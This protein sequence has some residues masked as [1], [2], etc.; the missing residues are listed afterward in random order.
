MTDT[1]TNKNAGRAARRQTPIHAFCGGN[2]GGKSLAM[3][4]D[5]LP[6]LLS[7][8][9]VLSTVELIDARTGQPFENYTRL[10]DWSQ[11]MEARNCDILFDEVVGIAG[12]REHAGLPVQVA[13]I[14]VQLRRRDVVL[15]WSAP[16]WQ[17]ADKIIREVTQA[18][19]ICSG[20]MGKRA[21]MEDGTPALWSQK[22]LFRWK[23]YSCADF[24]EWNNDKAKRISPEQS[25][26]FWAP[27]SLA[28][29]SY[30][31]LGDVTRV[32]ETLDS[33]R[34]AHCNGRRTVPICKCDREPG[35]A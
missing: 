4:H 23:T 24:E 10:T 9:K 14:L 1:W 15:R 13:N 22:R 31:T 7:G 33:G 28:F 12:S 16:A 32:G 20:M 35:H 25:A 19:T 2:G 5:T 30:R 3:V 29:E 17:R 26:W 6:S 11:L 34:C 8:R 18:V 21:T 27:G